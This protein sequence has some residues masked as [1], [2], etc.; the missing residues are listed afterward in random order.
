[1]KKEITIKDYLTLENYDDAGYAWVKD[2]YYDPTD[3]DRTSDQTISLVTNHGFEL[4]APYNPER[5]GLCG[6]YTTDKNYDIPKLIPELNLPID[7]ELTPENAESRGYEW[8]NDSSDYR[9]DPDGAS[10][11]TI[12][13]ITKE[14]YRLGSPASRTSPNSLGW[15]APLDKSHE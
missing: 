5:A 11:H 14:G 6:L 9:D 12:Y 7:H 1:M 15:Y 4:G 13:L 10:D 3:P 2:V 8:L